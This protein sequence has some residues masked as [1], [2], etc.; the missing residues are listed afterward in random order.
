MAIGP[1][2]ELLSGFSH[3]DAA[4]DSWASLLSD[5]VIRGISSVVL[6]LLGGLDVWGMASGFAGT[7]VGFIAI[8]V[9][10]MLAIWRTWLTDAQRRLLPNKMKEGGFVQFHRQGSDTVAI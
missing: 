2:R 4:S 3:R 6:V 5:V 7:I 9:I 1:A 10:T 8:S